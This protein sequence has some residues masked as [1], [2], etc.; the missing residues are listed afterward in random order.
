[1]NRY[2]REKKQK[3]LLLF[4][5]LLSITLGYG[6]ISSNLNIIGTSNI[7]NA[8]WDVHWNN[9]QVSSGSVTGTN[10]TTAAHILTGN[11]EVEYSITLGTPGDFYEF[12]VNAVNAGSIDAM[13]GSFTNKVYQ[14][15]GTTERTL[16]DYLIYSVTYS[17]GIPLASNHLLAANSTETYKVRVEFKRDINA[18]QLPSSADTLVFKFNV[19]YIQSDNNSINK[20]DYIFTTGE[21]E[22][23]TGNPLPAG[24]T[25]FSNYDDTMSYYNKNIFLKH[26]LSNGLIS[27][28]S[29]GFEISQADV[30]SDPNMTAGVYYLKGG[31]STC[32]FYT[33][34]IVPDG[35]WLCD[36]DSIYYQENKATL[37][38]AFGSSNC[39][40]DQTFDGTRYSTECS[41]SNYGAAITNEG[42]VEFFHVGNS[43]NCYIETYGRSICYYH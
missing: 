38:S 3:Y 2:R 43:Y 41:G 23:F 24:I 13:I 8:S 11:T 31:G 20:P 39:T 12:T 30:N 32:E 14:S 5:L 19:S 7:N 28:N 15:N 22:T 9:V 40:V 29:I 35:E 34:Q 21:I 10:V 26:N 27:L 6:L 4:L 17:D 37:I 36:A 25:T 18:N 1:M 42:Y 33:S 16:P